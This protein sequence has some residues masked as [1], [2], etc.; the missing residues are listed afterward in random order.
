[1]VVSLNLSDNA[2]GTS[3]INVLSEILSTARSASLSL[4]E[5]KLNNCGLSA[6]AMSM[7][8]S[9]SGE[10]KSKNNID[11]D[12]DRERAAILSNLTSLECS[13]N[14]LGT[15]G[16]LTLVDFICSST[17]VS[18]LKNF[19]ASSC[20]AN[21]VSLLKSLTG[22]EHD[23]CRCCPHLETL[24]LADNW[25]DFATDDASN[26]SNNNN[27]CR[28]G[29]LIAQ[30]ILYSPRLKILNLADM[31]LTTE[32]IEIITAVWSSSSLDIVDTNQLI[33]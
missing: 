12:S 21:V 24:D 1:M 28:A 27:N 32:S 9:S 31:D 8:M 22:S 19:K 26:R 11:S 4:K 2:L 10:T 14:M 6:E 18:R 17:I 5:L 16:F 13:N 20:R 15:D 30:V 23:R 7:L 3:G 25:I 29:N 33:I